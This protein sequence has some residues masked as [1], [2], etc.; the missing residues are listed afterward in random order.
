MRLDKLALALVG[1]I[2]FVAVVAF[3]QQRETNAELKLQL[4][5]L[6]HCRK[7]LLLKQQRFY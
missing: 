7:N 1:V 3:V 6:Y 5:E 2:A 4:E